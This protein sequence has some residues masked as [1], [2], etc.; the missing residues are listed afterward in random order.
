MDTLARNTHISIDQ[1]TDNAAWY[2]VQQCY[3]QEQ[4]YKQL[5]LDGL[6]VDKTISMFNNLNSEYEAESMCSTVSSLPGD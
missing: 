5:M 1:V 3:Q 2:Y 4:D 6:T